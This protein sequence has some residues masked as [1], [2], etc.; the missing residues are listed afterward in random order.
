MDR[1]YHDCFEKVKKEL[2]SWC[3]RFLTVF[4][5]ITV[6]KTMCIPKFTH[7]ATVIPNLSIG[8]I[9]DNEREFDLLFNDNNPS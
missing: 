9:K 2:N 1:N 5:K 4:V 6:I 3:H 8:Q 7:I